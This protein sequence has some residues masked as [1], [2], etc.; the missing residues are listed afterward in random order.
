MNDREG[1]SI[2]TSTAPWVAGTGCSRKVA[3]AM[4]PRVPSEPVN[5]FARSYPA[6]FFTTFPPARATVP[7]ANTTVIPMSRSR[8]VP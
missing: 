8:T 1:S 6:T 5:S 2:A 4:T 7:S 3:P